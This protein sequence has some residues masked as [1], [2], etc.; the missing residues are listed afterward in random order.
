MDLAIVDGASDKIR[1]S[2]CCFVNS[3]ADESLNTN[4]LYTQLDIYPSILHTLGYTI[5]GDRLALGTNLFSDQPTLAEQ[6][7]LD[8]LNNEFQKGSDFYEDTF[9]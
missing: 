3:D 1:K 9:S 4:R 7:G 2:Y 5:E 6:L 8:Y